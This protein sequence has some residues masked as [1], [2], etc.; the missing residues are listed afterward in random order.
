MTTSKKRQTWIMGDLSKLNVK[1]WSPWPTLPGLY[2][3]ELASRGGQ[4]CGHLA[5]GSAQE[6]LTR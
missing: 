6:G 4:A 3:E 2:M 5:Q 1:P